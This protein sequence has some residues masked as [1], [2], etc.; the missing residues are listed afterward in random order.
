MNLININ[1]KTKY[2][3]GEMIDILSKDSTSSFIS[4]GK[5]Y[6]K[7]NN[8][9]KVCEFSEDLISG[10]PYAEN[11]ELTSEL[12]NQTFYKTNIYISEIITQ[13]NIEEV[14]ENLLKEKPI[15]FTVGENTWIIEL[16]D[17]VVFLDYS[18][19][20]NA[21][22]KNYMELFTFDVL[23]GLLDSTWHVIEKDKMNNH[24]LH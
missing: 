10:V 16:E 23:E 15:M 11:L 19:V 7:R 4:N 24:I 14:R 21:T 22:D 3:F 12:T 2:T 18:E 17:D 1:Y 13:I 5:L 9:F 20:S 8:K 6:F